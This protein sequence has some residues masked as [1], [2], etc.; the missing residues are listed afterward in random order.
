MTEAERLCRA[1]QIGPDLSGLA[2]RPPLPPTPAEARAVSAASPAPGP[3]LPLDLGLLRPWREL[4]SACVPASGCPVRRRGSGPGF[5]AIAVLQSM[6]LKCR[7][8]IPTDG[9][10]RQRHSSKPHGSGSAVVSEL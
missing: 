3:R 8:K 7:G 1:R 9:C 2:R 10:R 6:S 5:G 4:L